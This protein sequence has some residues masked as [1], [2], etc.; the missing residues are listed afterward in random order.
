MIKRIVIFF[1]LVA[2]IAACSTEKNTFLSRTYHNIT[3]KYNIFFNGQEAFKAGVEKVNENFE[4]NY[5][6]ILPVFKYGNKDVNSTASGD[7]EKAIRK[8]SKLIKKHSITKKPKR[9]RGRKRS[10]KDKE[11]YNQSDFCKW[12]DDSYLLMGKAYFYRHEFTAAR[13]SLQFVV[14][15]FSEKPTK[16]EALLWIA[17]SHI[18]EGDLKNGRMSLDELYS[19][20]KI[21]DDLKVPIALTEAEYYMAQ[22]KYKDAIPKL[23]QAI[24]QIR[25]KRDRARYTYILAQIYHEQGNHSKATDLYDQVLKMNPTYEMAFNAKISMAMTV[26]GN[27]AEDIEKQ[28]RK[29]LKD[30]KNDDFR[31][32]IYYA[33]ANIA[34]NDNDTQQA[35]DYYRLSSESSVGNRNQ[36]AISCLALANILFEEQQYEL[37]QAY[38]DST[39]INLN[40]EYP[41]YEQIYLKTKYLTN[42]VQNIKMVNRQDSLQRIAQMPE[43]QRLAFIDRLIQDVKAAEAR[44]EAERRAG[45]RRDPLFEDDIRRASASGGSSFPFYNPTALSR[46]QVLF[47]QKWGDRKLEDN[48]R[49]SNKALV[50][51]DGEQNNTP[52]DFENPEKAQYTNKDREYYLVD[53]PLSDSLMTVSHQRIKDAFFKIGEVYKERLLDYPKAIEAFKEL[54]SR[55][56]RHEML[57]ASYYNIYR[58]YK[59]LKDQPNTEKYKNKIIN[60]FP[61]STHAKLL[62]DP[63]YLQKLAKEEQ[64]VEKFYSETYSAYQNKNYSKV[65]NNVKK[66]E[67]DFPDNSFMPKFKYLEALS[68]G[69]IKAPDITDFKKALKDLI[70]QYPQSDVVSP[71]EDMVSYLERDSLTEE[72]EDNT[73][74]YEPKTNPLHH[75]VLVVSDPSKDLN[76][77]EF[78]ITKFNYAT[79]RDTEFNVSSV[80]LKKGVSLIT[81]KSMETRQKALEYF[82]AIKKDPDAL[83]G[84]EEKDYEHFVISSDNY[85]IFFK[86]KNVKKYLD[87]FKKNYTK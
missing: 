7:M 29:M 16:F 17:R 85:T 44:A 45:N 71:A 46:G 13:R 60:E 40:K 18:V 3:A 23:K 36:K 19:S 38:Y 73:K 39:I 10:K 82:E 70:A 1:V 54:N 78:G 68:I 32:Q 5:T 72:F 2:G 11:F 87:F 37:A 50:M 9:K 41:G 65:M 43:D 66:A 57:L 28:L 26:S 4:D 25:R 35:K 86:D 8:A 33:L 63:N 48:W 76:R 52:G 49:R 61:N 84:L 15:K 56:P 58:S 80:E 47:R 64:Q 62:S 14:M 55:Y 42:L 21:P 75:Y 67:N 34:F 24:R 22:E 30:E 12:V 31:D 51:Q 81:V 59:E 79:F 20:G 27:N 69:A 53:L 77:I 6:R 74:L 83:E